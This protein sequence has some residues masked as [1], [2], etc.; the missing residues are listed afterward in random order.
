[1]PF[2]RFGHF[3]DMSRIRT[4]ALGFSVSQPL[5]EFCQSYT[6]DDYRL[7]LTLLLARDSFPSLDL[8]LLVVGFSPWTYRDCPRVLRDYREPI[9]FISQFR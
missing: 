7:C 1:M 3:L 6:W 4:P 9:S 2:P 8:T 5:C